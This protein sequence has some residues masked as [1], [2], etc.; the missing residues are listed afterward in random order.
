MAES[1]TRQGAGSSPLA[2][3][4][5]RMSPKAKVLLIVLVASI[6]GFLMNPQAP[7]GAAIFGAPPAGGPEP[8]GGQ[9]G[10]LMVVATL[11]AIAFGCGVAFLAMG[12]PSVRRALPRFAV[13]AWLAVSW[14]LVSWVPHT[15]LH[16]TAGDNFAKLV[17]IEYAFHVTLV[18]GGALL[19][20]A[21]IQAPSAND[22]SSARAGSRRPQ[23]A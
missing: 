16:Q 21:L 2:R 6:V 18:L 12:L 4:S 20:W 3:W 13:P 1:L 22:T 17:G 23:D 5:S 10:A 19:A 9:I 8:T 14:L 11:E 15:A 7:L